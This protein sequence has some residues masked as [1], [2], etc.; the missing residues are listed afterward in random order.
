MIVPTKVILR[1]GLLSLLASQ[2]NAAVHEILAA[3]PNSWQ[4]V[5][6]PEASQ[7]ITLSVA[8][9]QQNL[10]K[11]ETTLY[12][13]SDPTSSQY[14]NHMDRDE[15]QAMIQ[16]KSE[17]N[18]AVLAWLKSSGITKVYSDGQYVNFATTIGTANQMLG[19]QFKTYESNGVKKIRTLQYSIPD[20]LQQHVD[21]IHPTTYF[22]K[23]VAQ[24]P[25]LHHSERDVEARAAD[26]SCSTL[27][28]PKCLKEIYNIN[29]TP[30]AKSGSRIGFGS[31][32]NQTARYEDLA[33]FEK[34]QG[35]PAQNFTTVLINGG[36][37]NQTISGDHGE[38]DLD[39]ENI[40]GIAHPLPIT[41]FITGGS[42]PFVP[43]IDEP[44]ENDNEP[45]LNYY[46]F[47]LSKKNSELPQVISNSYGEPEETVPFKYAT[48]VCN[49]IAQMGCR[50]ISVLESSGDTGVGAGCKSNDGK[51]RTIFIPQF[52]GTCPC[53]QN[54]FCPN[55]IWVWMI[56]V[57]LQSASWPLSILELNNLMHCRYYCC[58]RN[59]I[60]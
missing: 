52:P 26:P 4:V 38:A 35:I 45:Y 36:V 8:L 7:L 16:P 29:Y 49:Q 60:N 25:I 56:R 15:L 2:A 19:A 24:A 43:S 10:D 12:A 54:S 9:Q 44:V 20:N 14:G 34:E 17:S 23:M 13:V 47:L 58:W 6:S 11:L 33:R 40:V 46:D 5:N 37:N 59:P 42:P 3:A 31:F 48:R 51:N 30:D 39:V 28:T 22:G 55:S 21:L 53:K 18:K 27:I 41:S 50:G 32:L 1:A 57:V